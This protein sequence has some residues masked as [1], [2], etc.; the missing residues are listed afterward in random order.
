MKKLCYLVIAF[1]V[2]SVP[3]FFA[4]ADTL[5]F[6]DGRLIEGQYMGGTQQTIRFQS[7]NRILVYPVKDVLA[8][9]FSATGTVLPTP[10]PS[11]SGRNEKVPSK[12]QFTPHELVLTPGTPLSVS[13]LDTIDVNTN[14]REDWFS[15]MLTQS[16]V[17]DGDVVIPKDTKVRGQVVMV[18]QDRA[19]AT[20][21]VEL[22]ELE[23]NRK[24][25]PIT[26]RPYIVQTKAETLIGTNSL[27]MVARPRTLQIP[28][29]TIIDFELAR[30][31][32][33]KK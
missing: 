12:P 27:K 24:I 4:W 25:V 2:F 5:E 31:L 9:T 17:V 18:Q 16:V 33:F 32:K 3:G 14:K 13:M 1:G 20:L 30:P 10:T 21:V 6:K 29:R 11:L 15:G 7:E 28:Y 23:L 26:T 22:K 8:L 19:G